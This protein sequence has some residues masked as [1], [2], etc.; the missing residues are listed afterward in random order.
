MR[1]RVC[2]ILDQDDRLRMLH[3]ATV[4]FRAVNGDNSYEEVVSYNQ[5]MDHLADDDGEDGL[6]HFKSIDAHQGPILPSDP[7]YNGSRYNLCITWENGE[8]TW[9]PLS[10]IGKADPVSVA[11]YGRENGLLEQV[12]WKT[13]QKLAKRQK[14]MLRMANQSKLQSFRNRVVFQFGIQVSQNHKQ[15]MEL[16]A[17]N[18]NTLWRDSERIELRQIN[19]YKAFDDL[20]F[21]VPA[22][23]GYKRIRVHMVY[24]IKHDLRRKSRLVADGNLTEVPLA[25]VYSSVVSLRGLRTTI[26]LAELNKMELWCTDIGNAYLEA[27]TLEK[28]YIVA[29]NEFGPLEGHTLVIQRA[30]YGLCSSGARWWEQLSDVLIEMGFTPSRAESDIWMRECNGDHY[31][32]IA[33]YVDDLAI[34]SR[35]PKAITDELEGKY[36]FK[37]KGTGQLVIT[38]ET[39][40]IAIRKESSAW[41]RRSTLRG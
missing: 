8:I 27:K 40:S 25:S 15:A 10:I 3:P 22:P 6:W 2:K 37:L 38:L 12:G 18:G 21:R 19:E 34:A 7:R 32:Y 5:I 41:H 29:G 28:I 31:E 23:K 17:R 26:F 4:K 13:F 1:L 39:I 20:G 33:R 9:E 35:D 24:A 11:I 14:K 16:D 36:S 30:L